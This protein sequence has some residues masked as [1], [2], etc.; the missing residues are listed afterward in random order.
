MTSSTVSPQS[1]L[2]SSSDATTV[3]M[4]A[5]SLAANEGTCEALPLTLKEAE[6]AQGEKERVSR[7]ADARF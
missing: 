3:A 7:G 4:L 2:L 5:G 1:S 6:I